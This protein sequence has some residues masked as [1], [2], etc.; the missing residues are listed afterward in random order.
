MNIDLQSQV[1]FG[2]STSMMIFFGDHAFA[3][4]TIAEAITDVTLQFPLVEVDNIYD[5]L[6]YHAAQHDSINA[7]LNLTA[8]ADLR[9]VDLTDESQFYDWMNNHMMLHDVINQTLGL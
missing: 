5:W 9:E 3:H 2:D 6:E 7:A 8:P 4:Q 1:T